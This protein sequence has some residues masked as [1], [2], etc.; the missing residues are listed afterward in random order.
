MAC[1]TRLSSLDDPR[2]DVFARLTDH[3]LRACLEEGRGI[4]IAESRMVVEVA[5]DASVEPLAFLVTERQLASSHDL[6]DRV[7]DEVCAF[8]L[9]EEE[10]ER[11]VGYPFTRG[12]L[13]AMRRP[14]ARTVAEVTGGA[15]R[16]A[17]AEDLVDVSNLGALV[18]SAAALGADA[19]VLSPGCAD[20]LC[21]RALRVSMGTTLLVPWARAE[22]SEWPAGTLGSL[23]DAGFTVC[24]LALGHGARPIDD[25]DLELG[26]KRA[27]VFGSEGPGLAEE[28]IACA[29]YVLTIPM[30]NGV[31]SLN[32]AA[33]SAVAFWQLFR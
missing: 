6:L 28:T 19:L 33:S 29:D 3:E 24:A 27:L 2:L 30:S 13:C 32:V 14:P 26:D 9:P 31:D 7:G 18:R 15:R 5:L 20:P 17:L 25:P 1:I 10:A 22:R 16:V 21:R 23:R 4:F 11:L 12:L 8:V